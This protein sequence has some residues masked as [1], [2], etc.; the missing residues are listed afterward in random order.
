VNG[1]GGLEG[2]F[3]HSRTDSS[4]T[5]DCTLDAVFSTTFSHLV[6]DVTHGTEGQCPESG[7]W[8]HNGNLHAVCTGAHP[9][10]A[11]KHWTVTATFENGAGTVSVVSG[12]NIW[13]FPADCE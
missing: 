11:E 13:N 8:T 9:G 3:T 4:G 7:I 6:F 2:S 1:T 10:D 12:D 5:T